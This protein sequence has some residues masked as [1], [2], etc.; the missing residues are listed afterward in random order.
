MARRH[1]LGTLPLM[2]GALSCQ[3]SDKRLIGVVPKGTS[4]LFWLSVHA[5]VIAASQQFDVEI[6]WN[7]PTLETEYARQIQIVDA[8]INRRIDGI[9]L[10]PAERT[11]LVSVVERAA[12][13]GIP[14]T[15]FDSGIGTENYVSYVA[16]NN[17]AAGALAAET[18]SQLVGGAG[19]VA[20]VKH[21][22]GSDSTDSRERGFEAALAK[23]HTGL[24]IVAQ[25]F[26]M[27]D[28]AKALAVTEDM[29][30]A[31]P[32][33]DALFCSSEAATI[34]AA[35]AL[36]ARGLAGKIKLTGFDASP[37]LQQDLRNG[38]IAALIVQ[39]PFSMG[40]IGVKTIVDKLDGK[41]PEKRIDSPARVV[42]AA[43]LDDPEVMKLMNPAL[44][45]YIKPAGA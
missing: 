37:S 34:G 16:T 25:Q 2:A 42:R 41:T 27:A 12:R 36:V 26:C 18:V 40:Y 4:S 11:A 43:D 3:R 30:T 29:L 9:V 38:V 1:F 6:E 35:R 33:L 31:H 28:R 17:V 19:K 20:L 32:D 44:E 15:I 14:V 8:M 23:T 24:E 7:G 21:S 13:E 10:S 22:P 5:G 39:D 45:K